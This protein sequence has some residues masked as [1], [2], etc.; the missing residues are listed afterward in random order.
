MKIELKIEASG[1]QIYA[2]EINE[3]TKN[4]LEENANND[5]PVSGMEI[6]EEHATVTLISHG[7]AARNEGVK[8]TATINGEEKPFYPTNFEYGE[9]EEDFENSDYIKEAIE[10]A[11]LPDSVDPNDCVW[12]PIGLDRFHHIPGSEHTIPEGHTVIF[13]IMP[14]SFG[15]L[16]TSIEVDEGFKLA[17]LKLVVDYPDNAE[18]DLAWLYYCDVFGGIFD[19]KEDKPFDEDTIRAV[20]YKGKRYDFDLDFQGGSEGW[21]EA[22]EKSGDGWFPS[23]LVSTHIFQ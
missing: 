9:I 17:D 23:F 6:V 16:H 14:Y 7:I 11:D 21:Y 15:T 19:Q 4:L 5:F 8:Y 3:E 13:E 1:I 2:Y 20:D 22:H 18:H 12:M 10:F